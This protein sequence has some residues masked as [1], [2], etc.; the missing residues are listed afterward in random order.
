MADKGSQSL[1]CNVCHRVGGQA[2][3][4]LFVVCNTR[5]LVNAKLE[6]LWLDTAPH[7]STVCLADVITHEQISQAFPLNICILQA[8]KYWRWEQ[9]GN[10][11]TPPV[12]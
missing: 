8:I 10:E 7:V 5:G 6:L 2:A 9:Q 1:P 12:H 4:I 3:S 11:A